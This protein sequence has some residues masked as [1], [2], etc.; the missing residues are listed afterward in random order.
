MNKNIVV[1]LDTAE[2][3]LANGM[4]RF[5]AIVEAS[6]T[7]VRPVVL[8]AITTALGVAPLLPDIVWRSMGITIMFGLIVGSMLTIVFVPVLYSIFY[9]V[10]APSS[11]HRRKP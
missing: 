8:A 6:V 2:A 7:R 4:G 10:K 3:N 11:V 5:E 1:L 9:R